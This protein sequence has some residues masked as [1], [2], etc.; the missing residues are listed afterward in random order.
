MKVTKLNGRYKVYKE[1]G[2]TYSV[3]FNGFGGRWKQ[4]YAFKAQA[5]A[6]FGDGG[7]EVKRKWMWREQLEQLKTAK[8]SHHYDKTSKPMIVYFRDKTEMEQCVM[9]FALMNPKV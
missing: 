9:M 4:F 2:Y 8:W 6:M 1:W 5:Q 3:T 7:G